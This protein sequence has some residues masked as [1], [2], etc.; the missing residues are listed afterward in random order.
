M[1]EIFNN[2]DFFFPNLKADGHLA[3]ANCN[4]VYYCD[5]VCQKNAWKSHHK[6]ECEYFRHIPDEVADIKDSF[7]KAM[8]RK[9]V[10][11]LMVRT[12]L[13]LSQGCQDEFVLPNGKKRRFSDLM[14]HKEEMKEDAEM[15]NGLKICFGLFQTWLGYKVPILLAN[16][17]EFIEI[18]GKIKINSAALSASNEDTVVATGVYLGYSAI[19]HSCAPNAHWYN[20]GTKLILRTMED[21]Q[22]FS[23]LR[24]TYL[25][26][27]G[28]GTTSDERKK[29][30]KREYYFDC[31]CSKCEDPNSDA[32]LMSL[33]CKKCDGWVYIDF[34]ICSKCSRRNHYKDHEQKIIEEFKNG[35][36]TLPTPRMTWPKLVIK[37]FNKYSRI[38]HPS[39][40]IFGGKSFDSDYSR[41]IHQP[42][43]LYYLCK[44]GEVKLT[45]LYEH[46]SKLSKF[47]MN[48]EMMLG[49]LYLM[50]NGR[51]QN[52]KWLYESLPHLEKA[53]EICKIGIGSRASVGKVAMK[54]IE[55]RKETAMLIQMGW[56]TMH[57]T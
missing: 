28:I 37:L 19:D 21:V 27:F 16:I 10:P 43:G 36:L 1:D 8:F 25:G 49:E 51:T 56:M 7:L 24:I 6:I 4:G 9:G 18:F 53:E 39:N 47:I 20:D 30:L 13:K 54:R 34:N 41:M 52:R 15:M 12:I 26:K 35:T 14:S 17:D 38:F 50:L 2:L 5:K 33:I 31:K 45:H 48:E 32:K 11:I 40:K 44:I 55:D 46:H 22:N 3:C 57:P 42:D 23:D 29:K